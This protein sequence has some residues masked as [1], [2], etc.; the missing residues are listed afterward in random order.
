MLYEVYTSLGSLMVPV[1]KTNS[2]NQLVKQRFSSS[3]CKHVLHQL[4]RD[5]LTTVI[6]FTE[7]LVI[8]QALSVVEYLVSL[9]ALL[10][11]EYL[12][13]LQ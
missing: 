4:R 10:F 12:V 8:R 11:A 2:Q 9:V 13:L 7:H 3:Y 1:V 5:G 6:T